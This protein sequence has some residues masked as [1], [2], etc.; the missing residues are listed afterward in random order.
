MFQIGFGEVLIVIIVAIC[1]LG[2]EQLPTVAK[3]AGRLLARAK[4]QLLAIKNE[5]Q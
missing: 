5:L 3:A 1:V 2:P 4:Q